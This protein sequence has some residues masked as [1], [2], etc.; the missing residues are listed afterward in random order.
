V[1]DTQLNVVLTAGAT[2]GEGTLT[3]KSP[4]GLTTSVKVNVVEQIAPKPPAVAEEGEVAA[5]AVTPAAA[6]AAEESQKEGEQ[7]LPQAVTP[8]AAPEAEVTTEEGGEVESEIPLDSDT[9]EQTPEAQ[10]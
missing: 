8:A 1:S 10:E 6:P 3:I 9:P 5:A 4:K 2:V 7:A